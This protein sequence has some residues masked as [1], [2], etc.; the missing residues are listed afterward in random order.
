M[1]ISWSFF[2]TLLEQICCASCTMLYDPY[3]IQNC[4][5]FISN[6]FSTISTLCKIYNK[7]QY[8]HI[9]W[10]YFATILHRLHCLTE[11]Q[12][13]M[14]ALYMYAWW[15][16]FFYSLHC[17][18]HCLTEVQEV[19]ST[20][21]TVSKTALFKTLIQFCLTGEKNS[22]VFP[23]LKLILNRGLRVLK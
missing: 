7:M 12:D 16:H 11:G 17:C 1:K 10:S 13:G 6:N 22:I 15:N 5:L 21:S 18:L 2:S 4:I 20:N 8:L 3:P 23:K 9:G 19:T 14:K